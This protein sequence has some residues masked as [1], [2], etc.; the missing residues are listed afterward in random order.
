M[1]QFTRRII[2]FAVHPGDVIGATLCRMFNKVIIG[3]S[4]PRYLS[5]DNDP[6]FEYHRWQ[7]NLRVLDIDEI[8]TA[9]SVPV[10]HP[11]VERLIGTIR[12]EFLDHVLFWNSTD[13]ERKLEEFLQYYNDHRVHASLNGN[14]PTESSEHIVHKQAKLQEFRWKTYC[15]DLVQLPLA[16]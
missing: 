5:S 10:S 9:R 6:L 16:A 15:R 13:L 14:T 3:N 2:G 4:L 8:K 11:F 7:A 12:R 1:D